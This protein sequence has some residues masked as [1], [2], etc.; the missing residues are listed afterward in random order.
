MY[1]IWYNYIIINFYIIR[2]IFFDFFNYLSNWCIFWRINIF[3][4]GRGG[5][6][7]LQRICEIWQND[8]LLNCRGL[9]IFAKIIFMSDSIFVMIISFCSIYGFSEKPI[10][11][12]LLFQLFQTFLKNSFFCPELFSDTLA[13]IY[14]I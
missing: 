12:F 1:M 13:K 5:T 4:L 6:L 14:V 9:N 3:S 7:P 11:K 2:I 8:N 10:Q